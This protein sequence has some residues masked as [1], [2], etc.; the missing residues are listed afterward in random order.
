VE[1]L[2]RRRSV[3]GVAAEIGVSE[4]TRDGSPIRILNVDEYTRLALG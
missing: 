3:G 4:T 1:L 2:R